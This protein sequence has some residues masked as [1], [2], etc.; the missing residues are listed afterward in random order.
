MIDEMID[1]V[2]NNYTF[3]QQRDIFVEEC[4]EAIQAVQKLKRSDQSG[5]EALKHLSEEVADV[6]ITAE[7]MRRYIGKK[8]IDRII[9]EKLIRQIKRIENEMHYSR[10]MD[11]DAP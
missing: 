11:G 5:V 4:A 2:M 8:T 6:L 10:R 9:S 1:K 7:Q 3:E